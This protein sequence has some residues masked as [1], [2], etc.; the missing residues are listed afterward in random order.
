MDVR[1]ERICRHGRNC[2]IIG[3][4]RA[5]QESGSGGRVCRGVGVNVGVAPNVGMVR[6]CWLCY[7]KIFYSKLV[8]IMS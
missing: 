4:S 5:F 3:V 7:L 6:L 1:Q 8:F 2:V